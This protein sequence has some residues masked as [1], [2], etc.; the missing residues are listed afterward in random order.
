MRL[1]ASLL[2]VLACSPAA[3]AVAEEP[4]GSLSVQA[5]RS[6]AM[7]TCY[8]MVGGGDVHATD[9]SISVGALRR[10][11]PEGF[12]PD[13]LERL[14]N[15]PD[16]KGEVF[17]VP[18]DSGRVL[19]I[20]HVPSL[21]CTIVVL[22]ESGE[23]AG[24]EIDFWFNGEP[25]PFVRIEATESPGGFSRVYEGGEVQSRPTRIQTTIVRDGYRPEVPIRF[26]ATMNRMP[27]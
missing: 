8:P 20:T 14:L 9:R 7:E 27:N 10:G 23:A 22:N 26:L 6:A 18:T 19:V 21:M 11:A 24:E 1:A 17:H 2:A 25:S 16:G 3:L 12:P 15:T 4:A 13:I 5:V